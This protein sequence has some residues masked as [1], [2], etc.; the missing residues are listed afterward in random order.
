MTNTHKILIATAGIAVAGLLIVPKLLPAQTTPG[1][2]GGSTPNP[3]GGGNNQTPGGG[4]NQTPGGKNPLDIIG[5]I[6]G[7]IFGGGGGGSTPDPGNDPTP[8]PGGGSDPNPGGGS[9]PNP[10]GGYTERYRM[11]IICFATHPEAAKKAG[12]MVK[13]KIWNSLDDVPQEIPF[14][15]LEI[16]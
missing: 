12:S 15:C 16:V 1:G 6:W 14:S 10:G 4:N 3:G 2:G 8:N 9:T 11:K 7:D 13:R 5:D